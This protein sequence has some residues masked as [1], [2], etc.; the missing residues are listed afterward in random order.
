MTDIE[1]LTYFLA[2][3]GYRCQLPAFTFDVLILAQ[4]QAEVSEL[5]SANGI[6]DSSPCPSPCIVDSVWPGHTAVT[7]LIPKETSFST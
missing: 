5:A 3:K 7:R 2:S 4:T 6:R 1:N